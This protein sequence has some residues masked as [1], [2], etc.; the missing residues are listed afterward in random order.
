MLHTEVLPIGVNP[1]TAVPTR[2]IFDTEAHLTVMFADRPIR[3]YPI[4]DLAQYAS[5][6]RNPGNQ[7][8]V[9]RLV[10]RLPSPRLQQG[11]VLVDTPGL[12]AL[13]TAG[14]AETMAYLPQCDLGIL[15]ISSVNPINDEDLNTIHA[16]SQA[17]TPVMVLLSK[18][19]L[20]SSEDRVKALAYTAQEVL[21]NLKLRLTVH[22]VSSAAGHEELL[23]SW[24][25]NELA[26]LYSR[27][28][29]LAQESVRR[30]AGALLESVTIALRAKAG[31]PGAAERDTARL[32]QIERRLREAAGHIEE[33]RQFCLSAVDSVRSLGA[34]AVESAAAALAASW[35]GGGAGRP[36]TPD[37]VLDVIERSAAG[38]AAEISSHL[39]AL[40]QALDSALRQA[41]EELGRTAGSE[42]SLRDCIREM[43][44]F[45]TSLPEAALA[46][47]WFRFSRRL[48]HSWAVH[49]LQKYVQPRADL[50]FTIYSRSLETWTRRVLAEMQDQFDARADTYRAQLGRLA[51]PM[52]VS[53]DEKARIEANVAGLERFMTGDELE[54]SP[55]A[56]DHRE[57]SAPLAPRT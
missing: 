57:S 5:E 23:E 13:A 28:R 42:G 31:L 53:P 50:G 52:K 26:P 32:E 48:A 36:D 37:V 7:L 30:K 2:L 45:E 14:A 55:T 16:L 15:L 29:E 8:E 20:L 10:V 3:R 40:A 51:S 46:A 56:G 9:T 22:P 4:G 49:K 17:G 6:E 33:A 24:F 34:Q 21:A 25:G 41:G 54:E 19:D 27:H 12:G 39:E 11:L 35:N 38:V 1:I 43:P 44:R 18:A 47:P